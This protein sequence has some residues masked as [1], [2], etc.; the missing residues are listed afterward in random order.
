MA[1]KLLKARKAEVES[2]KRFVREIAFLRE[3]PDFGGILPLIDSYLP[4]DPTRAHR[5]WLAMPVATLSPRHWTQSPPS[6]RSCRP[7]PASPAPLAAL[8]GQFDIGH[9]DIK[10]GNLYELGGDFLVGDFGLISVPGSETLACE[11]RQVGPANFTA[12]EMIAN[13]S[14]ADPHAAD[15]YSL[16]KTLWVLAAGQNWPPLGHQPTD[17]GGFSIAD[18]RPHRNAEVAPA[19]GCQSHPRPRRQGGP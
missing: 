4:D 15:V 1:L 8:Q 9:R 2:Y 14:T 18:F 13:P 17:S 12:Y 10:A 6:R 16:G 3:H 5:P 19:S 7:S 11:G